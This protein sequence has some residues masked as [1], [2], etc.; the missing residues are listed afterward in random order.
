[1]ALVRERMFVMTDALVPEAQVPWRRMFYL[2][3]VVACDQARESDRGRAR[4]YEWNVFEIVLIYSGDSETERR[5][6][7][8]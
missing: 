2:C 8:T 6:K 1:M 7:P 4:D 3:V 5:M